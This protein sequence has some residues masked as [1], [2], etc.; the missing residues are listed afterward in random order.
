MERSSKIFRRSIHT[1]LNNYHF[2]TSTAALLA[3]PFSVSFLLSQSFVP[4]GGPWFDSP[5]LQLFFPAFGP[6]LYSIIL[7]HALI[8]CNFALVLSGTEKFGGFE[9]ILKACVLIRDSIPVALSLAIPMNLGWAA[10]EALFQYRVVRA[11]RV[12]K[13]PSF[14]VALEGLFI[15]YLYSILIVLDTIVS[16]IFF[17]SC[18]RMNDLLCHE[19]R[20]SCRIEFA[21]DPEDPERVPKSE[22]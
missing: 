12:T 14:A 3:L 5:S 21:E 22:S 4:L 2:F 18:K 13:A 19:D 6:I 20:Y 16:C 8:V 9:A 11:Y 7:A 15:A 10:V 17:K 1:F